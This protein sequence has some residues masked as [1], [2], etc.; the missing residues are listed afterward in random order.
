MPIAPPECD[1]W[2]AVTLAHIEERGIRIILGC[3]GC[4]RRTMVWPRAYAEKHGIAMDM[5]L[6]ALE[7]RIRCMTCNAR[8]IH[9]TPEPY[10]I[11]H[12]QLEEPS[13]PPGL[14]TTSRHATFPGHARSSRSP[15]SSRAGTGL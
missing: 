6:K 15:R 2:K 14:K 11:R 8:L 4:Q 9:A 7:R 13:S 3:C 1:A 10:S 12:D 5:P